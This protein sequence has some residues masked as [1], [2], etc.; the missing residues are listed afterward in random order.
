MGDPE[1]AATAAAVAQV[2]IPTR[3]YWI[4]SNKPLVLG[5]GEP[6]SDSLKRGLDHLIRTQD[7]QMKIDRLIISESL[8]EYAERA[9]AHYI[10]IPQVTCIMLEHSITLEEA[11]STQ[12]WIKSAAVP[13]EGDGSRSRE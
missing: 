11:L 4:L 6:P 12:P 9:H 13:A 7:L 3:Y 5:D 2:G 8:D 1:L 10:Y